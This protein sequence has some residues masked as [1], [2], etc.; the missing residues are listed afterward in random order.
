L[1][2]TTLKKHVAKG[3]VATSPVQRL[4]PE[5]AFMELDGSGF[6]GVRPSGSLPDGPVLEVIRPEGER[7]LLRWPAGSVVDPCGLVATFLE[8]GR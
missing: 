1:N 4:R 8:R 7:M 6:L 3:Q 2:H 5:P